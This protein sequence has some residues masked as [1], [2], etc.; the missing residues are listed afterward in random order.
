MDIKKKR[1]SGDY[2]SEVTRAR[3]MDA[4]LDVI[5]QEGWGGASTA[6]IC[7]QAKVS[8]GAQTHH[9]PTKTALFMAAIDRLARQYESDISQRMA[10][11]GSEEVPLRAFLKA[12]WDTMLDD[13]YMY[14][15]IEALVA[16]RT[17]PELRKPIADLDN[18]SAN[19][20]RSMASNIAVSPEAVERV[21]DAIELSTYLFRSLVIQRGIHDDEKY[22][23]RLFE[24][25]CNFIEKALESDIKQS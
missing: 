24:V 3:L 16:G 15:A 12:L 18:E 1:A 8:S 21:Q 11:I 19:S 23:G 7:K 17:N 5:S 2:R 4:T 14:S 13:Q 22:K 20:L 10:N 6:K 25:W 9:F